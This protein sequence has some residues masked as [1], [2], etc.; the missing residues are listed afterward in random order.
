VTAGT[1]GGVSVALPVSKTRIVLTTT[2]MKM[3]K[4]MMMMK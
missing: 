1:K 4:M 2:K 3:M